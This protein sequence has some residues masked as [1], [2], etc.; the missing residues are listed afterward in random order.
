MTFVLEPSRTNIPTKY[1]RNVQHHK[2]NEYNFLEDFGVWDTFDDVPELLMSA[3]EKVKWL[4]T[5]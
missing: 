2:E 5:L 1:L 3:E 4:Q